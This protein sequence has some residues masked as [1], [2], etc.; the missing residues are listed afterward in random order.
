[1]FEQQASKWWATAASV[2]CICFVDIADDVVFI[3][4]AFLHLI[5]SIQKIGCYY[6]CHANLRTSISIFGIYSKWNK[7]KWMWMKLILLNFS[8]SSILVISCWTWKMNKQT[9]TK[10]GLFVWPVYHCLVMSSLL[11]GSL[12]LLCSSTYRI[13]PFVS[14]EHCEGGSF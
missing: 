14:H 8:H 7:M 13:E 10:S 4:S 3:F 11:V 12:Q 2:A 5:G 1:M 6:K 9:Y